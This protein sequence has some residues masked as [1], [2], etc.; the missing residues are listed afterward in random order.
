MSEEKP[1]RTDSERLDFFATHSALFV[2]LGKSWYAKL[3]LGG[4]FKKCGDLRTA[5]DYAMN[6][7]GD[8][9]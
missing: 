6:K 5:I 4:P 3:E 8:R 7:K 2:N 1:Q 9:T